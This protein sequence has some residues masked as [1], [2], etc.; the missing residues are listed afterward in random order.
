VK[1]K[2]GNKKYTENL[3]RAPRRGEGARDGLFGLERF[4]E[5]TK[6]DQTMGLV[7]TDGRKWGGNKL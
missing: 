3:A 2:G 4:K 7:F 6:S 1:E 5:E